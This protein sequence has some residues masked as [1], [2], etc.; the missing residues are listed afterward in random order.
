MSTPGFEEIDP[1]G[2]LGFDFGTT[3]SHLAYCRVP[4]GK[5]DRRGAQ[6]VGDAASQETVVLWER[7]NG[8]ERAIAYGNEALYEW[9]NLAQLGE[10]E[11]AKRYRFAASFKPDLVS[12]LQARHDAWGFLRKVRDLIARD[13]TVPRNGSAIG[14]PVVMGVPARIADEHVQQTRAV[15]GRAGLGEVTCVPEPLGALAYHLDD[16]TLSVSQA[17]QGVI[18]VDFGGG[19]LD[20]ALI[21]NVGLRRP[22]GDPTL[23]GRLFDDLF[24]SWLLE[25]HPT[26]RVPPDQ[27]VYT[28]AFVCRQLKEKVST[29]WKQKGGDCSFSYVETVA[30]R[31]VAFNGSVAELERRARSYRPSRE[32]REH[33]GP[34][35]PEAGP[36]DLY[37]RIEKALKSAVGGLRFGHVLLTG[38][39]CGWPFMTPLAMRAFGVPESRVHRA[40]QPEL[41]VGS[42]LAVYPIL[43]RD[44]AARQEEHRQAK[45]A[46]LG[47]FRQGVAAK[48]DD[49]AAR[50]TDEILDD[51]KGKVEGEFLEWHRKGGVLRAVEGRIEQICR[52]ASPGIDRLF[53]AKTDELC[54]AVLGLMHGHLGEWLAASKIERDPGQFIHPVLKGV[55]TGPVGNDVGQA[56]ADP[57]A[58]AIAGALAALTVAV[59]AA[60]KLTVLTSLSVALLT[61]VG[62]VVAAVA[63]VLGWWFGPDLVRDHNWGNWPFG[64]DLTLMHGV[65]SEATLKKRVQESFDRARGELVGKVRGLLGDMENQAAGK[66]D[67]VMELVIADLGIL[68]AR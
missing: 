61:P 32:L 34:A 63:F 15:A 19:T 59:L 62:V 30:G 64:A 42:G 45:P 8:E 29:R 3:T 14:V 4:D 53:A 1:Q 16:G 43:R 41:D 17:R 11:R 46:T 12:S 23:G 44:L 36:I 20:V 60:V 25:Q 28:W 52:D 40:R 55:A 26:V 22:W 39:S 51:L 18:V 49:F 67:E 27:W 68:D 58:K 2:Y 24:Y 38:G 57:V 66:L 31:Q 54:G 13:A 9:A 50:I 48:L 33:L 21:D 5:Q 10:Q 47:R 35:A 56:V 37:A 6:P 65:L 7:V